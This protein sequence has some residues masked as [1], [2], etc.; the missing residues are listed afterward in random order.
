MDL[1]SLIAYVF[2]CAV[3]ATIGTL[4][5]L[6]PLRKDKEGKIDSYIKTRLCLAAS[7]FIEGLASLLYTVRIVNEVPHLA[8]DHFTGPLF[9]YFSIC[10]DMTAI[11]YLLHGK[12]PKLRTAILFISPVLLVW[13]IHILL[14]IPDYGFTFSAR[15]YNEFLTT[16]PAAITCYAL[17][18]VFVVEFIYI[19]KS[20]NQQ[21]I[22][23]K[24]HIDNYCSGKSRSQSRWLIAVVISIVTYYIIDI[25]DMC[26]ST[27][28]MDSIVLWL[29]SLIIIVNSMT[30]IMCR[31]IY[32]NISP[33]F[34]TDK[35]PLQRAITAEDPYPQTE[36]P[37]KVAKVRRYY[38]RG[39]PYYAISQIE[40]NDETDTQQPK[41]DPNSIDNIVTEWTQRADKP[42]LKESITIMQV[43]EQMG[44]NT[45]LLSNYLNSVKGR[46]FNAWINYLKVEETK[47]LLLA[48]RSVSLSDIAYKMGFT[49]LASM[50]KIFK[51]IEGMPPSVYRQT[52]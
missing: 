29:L 38:E 30:F 42:Y 9:M 7:A 43:A 47:L 12:Q 14:F 31:E 17:Y 23:F 40:K 39:I 16:T 32:W 27:P 3:C 52:H 20:V 37:S 33:A 5:L 11:I 15:A 35:I 13:L 49:D 41:S 21:I 25:V 50:S 8:L 34:A 45:R 19:L 2:N 4:F 10:I 44:L 46:N 51:S 22:R 28:M 1:Y 36:N 18:A 24:E 48:D 6:T 26:I